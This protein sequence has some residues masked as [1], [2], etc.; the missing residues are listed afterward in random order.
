M[1]ALE[2]SVLEGDLT[3]VPALARAYERAGRTQDQRPWD[4]V[5]VQIK[6]MKEARVLGL[7]GRREIKNAVGPVFRDQ[8]V[9]RMAVDQRHTDGDVEIDDNAEISIGDGPEVTGCYIQAWVW[10]PLDREDVVRL[11]S[12]EAT[13][14]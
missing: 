9:T 1:R 10:I 8:A 11:Q 2:R 14:W 5:L 12:D 4:D 3:A 7:N 6:A 13:G